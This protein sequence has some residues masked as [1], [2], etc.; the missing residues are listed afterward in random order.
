MRTLNPPVGAGR[1]IL[2]LMVHVV[3]VLGLLA[4]YLGIE[5]RGLNGTDT[6][7]A[8]SSVLLLLSLWLLVS[9]IMSEGTLLNPYGLFLSASLPFHSGY[10]VLR[11][12]DQESLMWLT[13]RVTEGALADTLT[14]VVGGYAM[15]HLGA[16]LVSAVASR[17][18][19]FERPLYDGT[20]IYQVGWLLLAIATV[21]LMIKMRASIETVLSGG[22]I[23]LFEG[24]G[25]EESRS[26]FEGLISLF[27]D[28]FLPG[29]MFLLAGSRNRPIGKVV[30]ILG[31]LI[32]SGSYLFL[33]FRA[34]SL[35]PIAVFVWV[36]H[37]T[38]RQLPILP[39]ALVGGGLFLIVAPLVRQFRDLS[40]S[41]RMS[42]EALWEAYAGAD[43]PVLA[44][45]AELAG[46]VLTITFTT[47][48]VPEMRPFEMGYGYLRA[49]ANA[50][51]ILDF[52][53][54]Y[55]YAGTW[56]AYSITPSL[57]VGGFGFGFSFMGEAYL[58]F[59]W[60]GGILMLGVI[61][62]AVAGLHRWAD[63]SGDL[64]RFAF[65]ASFLPVLIFY[66][67]GE[68]I[69]ISR[70]ILWYAMIPYV[71]VLVLRSMDRRIGAEI[72]GIKPP[73]SAPP[74]MED[75][76]PE[77]VGPHQDNRSAWPIETFGTAY[78]TE[79][80]GAAQPLPPQ[81]APRASDNSWQDGRDHG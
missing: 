54:V 66:T 77:S 30:A 62:A 79:Q 20:R 63:R 51:P 29:V 56:L 47:E 15:L 74:R 67:R 58:N 25:R 24:G 41:D 72:P 7:D 42:L 49:L 27:S 2:A 36:W 60:I 12:L 13:G 31:L 35:I 33:G 78:G 53:D 38:I 14:F 43:N 81:P 34:F 45:I 44:L 1:S 10:S 64:A 4:G 73:A 19:N 18:P 71:L 57:A 69:S 52:P 17:E 9:W 8:V 50:I 75:R 76:L 46:S 6:L 59:G 5:A 55:G 21:P 28:F 61:G 26:G 11:F 23:S 37:R 40:G 70:P 3:I 48:L 39:V 68:S 22:Y 32:Y 65:I 16:L 80:P